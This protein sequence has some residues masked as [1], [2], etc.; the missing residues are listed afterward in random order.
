MV[1]DYNIFDDWTLTDELWSVGPDSLVDS[2]TWDDSFK[3]TSYDLVDSW[4]FSDE[5]NSAFKRYAL[6]DSWTLDESVVVDAS[7][8]DDYLDDVPS[9]LH[10]HPLPRSRSIEEREYGRVIIYGRLFTCNK[11]AAED[12]E[13]G[14][15]SPGSIMRRQWADTDDA[16]SRFVDGPRVVGSKR[17]QKAGT[18]QDAIQVTYLAFL[19]P[20]T[21]QTGYNETARSQPRAESALRSLI[22]VYGITTDI[23]ASNMPTKGSSLDGGSAVCLQVSYNATAL[24]GRILVTS[25]YRLADDAVDSLGV[26]PTPLPDTDPFPPKNRFDLWAKMYGIHWWQRWNE[27]FGP[28]SGTLGGV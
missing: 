19:L 16:P 7:D 4:T 21:R 22:T 18:A 2:F 3:F 13:N 8:L 25:E 10:E 15:L 1:A 6:V 20:N 26:D 12:F 9:G 24:P 27:Y 28:T 14:V 23:R 5:T 17:Q 11:G